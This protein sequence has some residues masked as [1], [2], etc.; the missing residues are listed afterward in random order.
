MI[1]IIFQTMAVQV[2]AKKKSFGNAKENQVF[3]NQS[4][5]MD[6]LLGTKLVMTRTYSTRMVVI[7]FVKSKKDGSAI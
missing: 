7:K 6:E 1:K 2:F 3:V 5:P 4:V